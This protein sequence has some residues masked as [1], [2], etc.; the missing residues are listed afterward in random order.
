[1]VRDHRVG[2]GVAFVESVA[3]ERDEDLED[4]FR[5]LGREALLNRALDERD[6]LF[7]EDLDFFFPIARRRRSA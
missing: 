4:F 1:M 5:V 2:R 6:F 7:R 3:R